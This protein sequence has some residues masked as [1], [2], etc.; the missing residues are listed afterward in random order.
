MGFKLNPRKLKLARTSLELLGIHYHL[1]SL[2]IPRARVSS[3]I[4]TPPPKSHKQLKAFLSSVSF[5]RMLIPDYS[6]IVIPL[7]DLAKMTDNKNPNTKC[8]KWEDSHQKAF[9]NVK[10]AILTHTKCSVPDYTKPFIASTDA[11]DRALAGILYQQDGD[12]ILPITV[13]SRVLTRSEVNW[14][15]FSKEAAALLFLLRA[16]RIFTEFRPLHVFCDCR[17]VIFLAA[18][19]GNV[20]PKLDC[21]FIIA[22]HECLSNR[23]F[24]ASPS[25]LWKKHYFCASLP[26]FLHAVARISLLEGK[27]AHFLAVIMLRYKSRK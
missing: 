14:S 12:K 4:A 27:I 15:I 3:Y 9:D 20:R 5:Y 10:Q 8:F 24:F 23:L 22:L 21:N 19:K 26:P 1:G 18:S 25:Q 2:S 13:I 11:S 16:T 7:L 6:N 17:A